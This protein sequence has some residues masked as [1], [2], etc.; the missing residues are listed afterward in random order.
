M[1][2][3]FYQLNNYT[4]VMS[5]ETVKLTRIGVYVCEAQDRSGINE[6]YFTDSLQPLPIT[7]ELLK[8]AGCVEIE[9]KVETLHVKKTFEIKINKRSYY[10]N[11]YLYDGKSVWR[12]RDFTIHH[13]HQL[14]QIL[15]MIE[16]RFQL[17]LF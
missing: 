17:E 11:G 14:Q 12:F 3:T 8:Q 6:E 7:P 5:K 15:T 2:D 10:L 1:I 13:F 4:T 9:H 16:P